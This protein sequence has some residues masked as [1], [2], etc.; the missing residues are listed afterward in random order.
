MKLNKLLEEIKL[1]TSK[2][3]EQENKEILLESFDEDL[4]NY[5]I[6][7]VYSLLENKIGEEINEETSSIIRTLRKIK[8]KISMLEEREN[9]SIAYATMKMDSLI[10]DYNS[11][12]DLVNRKKI[13]RVIDKNIV[14]HA[15]ALTEFTI[16]NLSKIAEKE[17]SLNELNE[18]FIPLV[19]KEYKIISENIG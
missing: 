3:K 12:I 14:A 13:Q 16:N 1:G 19:K 7:K 11:L 9:I 17:Y 15:I 18:T 5:K 6:S 10:E 4:E 2:F 8:N